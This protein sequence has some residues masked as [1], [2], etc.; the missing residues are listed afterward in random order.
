[1]PTKNEC[2]PERFHHRNTAIF[3]HRVFFHSIAGE[4]VIMRTT[5]RYST[6]ERA[7]V[8]AV[9]HP[10]QWSL[11]AG[12]RAAIVWGS[13][14]LSAF[15]LVPRAHADAPTAA[16]DQGGLAEV[17]VTAEKY[18]STIQETPIS[19]SA[20]SSGQLE[21][22]GIVNVED[23]ARDV[24]GLS[25]RSAG[26]GLTEYDARGLA[27]NGGAA[28]TVGFY[29]D[30]IPLSPPALSQSGKVVIDPNLY[31]VD[32]VE[33][34]RG[35]QG[36]LYGSGS[37]GG[38]V[39]VITQQPKLNLFEG[40]AQTTVSDTE[41][42]GGNG[43]VN[44][45]LNLPLGDKF[46]LRVVGG[47][48]Y[49][50]GWINLIAVNVPNAATT[51]QT[52]NQTPVYN[53]PVASV[54]PRANTERV[55]DA[56]VTLLFQPN[57]DLSITAM[58]LDQRLSLG[59]YDLLD[60]SPT[61]AQPGKVYDA[62]Y[63]VFPGREYL[64]DDV[65]IYAL[66]INA[67]VGFADL[68]SA[69]SYFTRLNHQAQ[70]ASESLYYSNVLNGVPQAPL[71]PVLYSEV[72]PS[73]QFSQELRL[74]SHDIGGLHWVA[75]AFWSSLKSIWNEISNSPLN[76]TP[77]TPDGS[78]FT[79]INPYWVKQTA[80]FADG[81]YKFD[82]HWK[83]SAGVRWYTYKSEQ[84]EFSWGLDAPYPNPSVTPTQVTRASDSGFNP[85]VN[86]S[87]EPSHDLNL[88]TTISKGFRPGG[89][90]Q[91]LPTGP[92][93]NCQPGVL[94]FGP[95]SAWNYEVGE[96]AKLFDNRL[97]INGDVYYIRWLDV[98]QVITL[99]CG[100]QYYNNAGNGRA[101]GPELEI[102][103]K[104]AEAW[105]M[106]LSG[107]Y[108]DSKIT[109]PNASFQNYLSTVAFAP[110]GV[111]RPCPVTGKC[112]VPILNVAKETASASLAYTTEVIP[113]YQLTARVDDSLVGPATDVAFYF[114]YH[115]PS[116]NIANLHLIL[117]HGPWSVNAFVTNFTNE[118]ALVTANNTSFQ[119]NIPQTV[120]YSTN[121]PRTYG[122]QLNVKF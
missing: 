6:A 102:N 70:D 108:T 112:T 2:R 57:E 84:H 88:Y 98:Q 47:D 7:C 5:L 31:D 72:D 109:A 48:L 67:N 107:A 79:S 62:H 37:M 99:P 58:A 46:A 59:G 93:I 73:H 15:C 105:T 111:T 19:I 80:L 32:R 26:P 85:R 13:S 39:K 120:R 29:L 36:T 12:L 68:T 96:K 54:I 27:S 53:A 115:L 44:A 16:P 76:A 41:G 87:Y 20:L 71:A 14:L 35:P 24:P 60:S 8:A 121:Q 78:Y 1:M 117:D 116:Y 55:W 95:D 56:R 64:H 69:T 75:G 10:T 100:Y 77:S 49:R 22:Q 42:G 122:M 113:N 101:Y 119:F 3:I 106:S 103:A 91:I 86:L 50:S 18:R 25:M 52:P 63:E 4:A 11:H 40:S 9:G 118:V 65:Q 83:L 61:S 90:N 17:V 66:T 33:V 74:T 89:A 51:L 92:P 82:D 104:L 43:S 34:L 45:M 110:D 38:T 23:I 21:A 28:P 30:E 81:S 94:A 114:G 97:T